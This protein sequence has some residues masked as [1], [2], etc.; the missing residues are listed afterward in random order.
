M[1]RHIAAAVA[2]IGA[3]ASNAT[4]QVIDSPADS[5]SVNAILELIVREGATGRSATGAAIADQIA[6]SRMSSWRAD[7]LLKG[8]RL[9]AVNGENPDVR[10]VAA[11]TIAASGTYRGQAVM[12][13]AVFDSAHDARTRAV[14]VN[15]LP[16]FPDMTLR[17]DVT[18]RAIQLNG[19]RGSEFL[20]GLAVLTATKM[21]D[22]GVN[23]LQEAIDNA[24]VSDVSR[25]RLIEAAIADYSRRRGRK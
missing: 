11:G 8:L 23:V 21:G 24:L 25:V 18:L 6:K 7:S 2:V 22:E 13:L 3:L 5:L 9:L 17:R 20:V 15:A 1:F 19:D 12:L 16:T 10:A 14:I 4:A